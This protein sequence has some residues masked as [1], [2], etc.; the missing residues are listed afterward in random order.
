M[1]A[2]R[3]R[4]AG[5][6]P[7]RTD[8]AG[9]APGAPGA[10]G[11]PGEVDGR[12]A[13]RPSWEG[14]HVRL[15]GALYVNMDIAMLVLPFV[16]GAFQ[17]PGKRPPGVF[18]LS[19]ALT[20]DTCL[21]LLFL[22]VKWFLIP[23]VFKRRESALRAH[24]R[25]PGFGVSTARFALNGLVTCMTL[26]YFPYKLHLL[27]YCV[28][29]AV[30]RYSSLLLPVVFEDRMT[31]R[32]CGCAVVAVC[33]VITLGMVR[34]AGLALWSAPCRA[35]SASDVCS[36]DSCSSYVLSAQAATVIFCALLQRLDTDQRV[37]TVAV[38]KE[39]RLETAV[40]NMVAPALR[41]SSLAVL[42][43]AA[44]F[45]ASTQSSMTRQGLLAIP[46][47]LLDFTDLKICPRRSAADAAPPAGGVWGGA[48]PDDVG[49]GEWGAD[50]AD[51]GGG[52]RVGHGDREGAGA[53]DAEDGVG[54]GAAPQQVGFRGEG[55]GFR[56]EGFGFRGEG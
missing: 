40:R 48:A 9:F 3:Y 34:H 42:L 26:Y 10:R 5:E 24:G 11:K 45:L 35:V 2:L 46:E 20:R 19:A 23:A 55:F 6:A 32:L 25:N 21:A 51:G 44:S 28:F 39:Q 4:G 31:C 8:A 14:L 15:A 13:L 52:G 49:S 50:A 22:L 1:S 43:T 36:D 37:P 30:L 41:I 7:S 54:G 29:S 12:P 18:W 17:P 53:G 47:S 38:S 27:A 56:G 16:S 33:N